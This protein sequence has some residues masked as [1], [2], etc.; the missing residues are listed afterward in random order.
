MIY[1]LTRQ[2]K[3]DIQ[4]I[5]RYTVET[6]GYVP[7]DLYLGG[8][9]YVFELLC[10]NPKLGKK[11]QGKVHRTLYKSHYVLYRIEENEIIILRVRSTRLPLPKSWL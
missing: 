2:A 6:F 4:D 1:R 11:V 10:E 3:A 7:S 5:D 9:D 8:L